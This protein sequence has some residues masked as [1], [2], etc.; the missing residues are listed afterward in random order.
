MEEK[1]FREILLEGTVLIEQLA[2]DKTSVKDF[3]RKY[4]NF[5]YYNALDG[6][7][8]ND[9]TKSFL[10]KYSLVISLH[11][12]IQVN[13][14]D[15]IYFA[16]NEACLLSLSSKEQISKFNIKQKLNELLKNYNIKRLL[17]QL[18]NGV[19]S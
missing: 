5:Y 16:N 2:L 19:G 8:A 17:T 14:V 4:N 12:D 7:E 9:Q 6:H 13:F 1:V 3:I 11:K 10:E 18:S 15:K